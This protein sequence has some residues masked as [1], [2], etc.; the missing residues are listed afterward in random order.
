V[1]LV[2]LDKAPTGTREDYRGALRDIN[3][4]SPSTQTLLK[5]AEL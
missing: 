5:V 3:G 2:G 1:S 4:D